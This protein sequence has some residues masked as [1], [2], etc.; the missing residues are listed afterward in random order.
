[1]RTPERADERE[2]QLNQPERNEQKRENS[3]ANSL[4]TPFHRRSLPQMFLRIENEPAKN[5][6]DL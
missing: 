1:M 4:R 2:W 5:T 6:C 3:N